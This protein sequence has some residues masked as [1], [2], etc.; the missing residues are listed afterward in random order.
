MSTRIGKKFIQLTKNEYLEPSPQQKGVVPQPPLAHPFEKGKTHFDLP[1]PPA[2]HPELK[3]LID[4]RSSVRRY[5][6]E[7]LTLGEL[8]YLL[9]CTQGVKQ[10]TPRPVTIRTVPSAGAR[11]ALET[12]LLI[13]RVEDLK[14]GLYR[15]L[16]LEH[17]ITDFM[18]RRSISEQIKDAALGQSMIANSAVTFIWTAVMDR[19]TWRYTER[20]Y[21]Y[22]FLDAG[23]VCQ[24]LYLSAE[25]VGL[26]TCAVGAFDDD[27][28]NELLE[29][30]GD[31][32]WVIYMASVGKKR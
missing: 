28:M 3:K 8:S 24:N 21:R 9:W 27:L 20:G 12:F 13:N 6:D 29:L 22:I 2:L 30:D 23:H 25:S 19:M 14:P 16:A 15:Y 5:Q 4:N 17:K 32:E 7:P 10:V 26:G 31:S 18:L 11:H 1:A